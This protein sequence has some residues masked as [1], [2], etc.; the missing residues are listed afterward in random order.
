MTK[1][2][3]ARRAFLLGAPHH[4]WSWVESSRGAFLR[5]GGP[6]EHRTSRTVIV[7]ARSAARAASDRSLATRKHPCARRALV[8][9]HAVGLAT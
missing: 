7:S 6:A 3:E 2:D 9:A 8:L 4:A 1:H 5:P